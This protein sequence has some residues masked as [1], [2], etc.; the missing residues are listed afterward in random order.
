LGKEAWHGRSSSL[1][2]KRAAD[3]GRPKEAFSTNE[4]SLGG[5]TENRRHTKSVFSKERRPYSCRSKKAF[6]TD[7][8]SMGSEKE[9][10]KIASCSDWR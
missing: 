2:A 4:S 10:W 5:K 8:G 7:E 3:T 6:G 9:G 1:E